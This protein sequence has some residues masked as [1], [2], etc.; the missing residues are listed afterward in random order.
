MGNYNELKKKALQASYEKVKKPAVG[1]TD[2][3]KA[4]LDEISPASQAKLRTGNYY[5]PNGKSIYSNT[6][7]EDAAHKE[8]LDRKAIEYEKGRDIHIAASKTKDGYLPGTSRE[9]AGYNIPDAQRKYAKHFIDEVSTSEGFNETNAKRAKLGLKPLDV[10]NPDKQ[11]MAPKTVLV[12]PKPELAPVAEDQTTPDT[13]PKDNFAGS[14]I[15]RIAALS[16]E[17]RKRLQ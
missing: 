11:E 1:Y 2:R 16:E 3:E 4:S 13:P 5:D 8:N 17:T 14:S 7:E 6:S 10:P 9:E 12:A 15:R